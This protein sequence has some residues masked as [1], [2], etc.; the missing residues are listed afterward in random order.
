MPWLNSRAGAWPALV[1]A[2]WRAKGAQGEVGEREIVW[3]WVGVV[4]GGRQ[5]ELLDGAGILY[6]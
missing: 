3:R 1:Q 6:G 5:E 2:L 4:H